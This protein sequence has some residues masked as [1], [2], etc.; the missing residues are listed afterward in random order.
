MRALCL[1]GLPLYTIQRPY[2]SISVQQLDRIIVGMKLRS[3]CDETK[4][5]AYNDPGTHAGAFKKKIQSSIASV[6]KYHRGLKL[7]DF[8]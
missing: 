7:A 2:L 5:A 4:R 8:E 6:R 3:P 1:G